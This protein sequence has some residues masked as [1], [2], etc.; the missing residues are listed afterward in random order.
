MALNAKNVPGSKG[1][2]APPLDTGMYPGRLLSVI[3]LGLQSQRPY[4]GQEK[5][6]VRELMVTYELADEFMPGED[7]QPDEERPR[8]V[9]ERFPFYSLDADKA[10]STQRYKAIDPNVEKGGDWP[11]LL[12]TPVNI[13]IVQSPGKDGRVF[14]NVAGIA[15]M[16]A[17]E[18]AKAVPLVNPS[19]AFD[20]D[21]P[22]LETWNKL[23]DWQKKIVCA[24]L[25]YEGS[26]LQRLLD[27]NEDAVDTSAPDVEDGEVDEENPY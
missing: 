27:A 14:N 15:P 2:A 21:E 12:G 1:P 16:R 10:K 23:H 6:P 9:S 11:A 18:A 24:N 20:S 13:S 8:V 5:P 19:F 4:K 7:G 3:D 25:E 17:K 26:R 22:E